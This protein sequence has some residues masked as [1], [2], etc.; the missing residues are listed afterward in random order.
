[1]EDEYSIIMKMNIISL[2][3][4][5]I[6]PML[7]GCAMQ[8]VTLNSVGPAPAASVSSVPM[9]RLKVFTATETHEIGDN[10]YY[11]PHTGYRICTDD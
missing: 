10:T 1:M 9:G 5:T 11:H 7:A 8:P 6:I 3:G 2:I 4:V